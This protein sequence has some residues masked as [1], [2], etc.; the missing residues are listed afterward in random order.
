MADDQITET[1]AVLINVLWLLIASTC[2]AQPS[3]KAGFDEALASIRDT[4]LTE[5]SAKA[6]ALMELIRDR[7]SHFQND[8]APL[9][10][11]LQIGGTLSARN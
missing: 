8:Q 4:F 2:V 11:L 3:R 10:K 7:P 6:A 1:E 5:N 9:N